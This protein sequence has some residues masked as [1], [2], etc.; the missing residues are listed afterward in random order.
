MAGDGEQEHVEVGLGA[1]LDALVTQQVDEVGV[2]LAA[3]LG[4]LP[5]GAS[6]RRIGT[7]EG[8]DVTQQ[9]PCPRGD[10]LGAGSAKSIA[11]G[12]GGGYQAST[13]AFPI[14]T[15]QISGPDSR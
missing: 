6:S 5:Y 13:A 7:G 11:P 8:V 2:E 15:C 14:L 9:A 10:G 12:C 3:G 1:G 4:E